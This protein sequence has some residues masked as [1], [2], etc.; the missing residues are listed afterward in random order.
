MNIKS[1]ALALAF[2]CVVLVAQG[3]PPATRIDVTQLGPQKGQ[4]VP[5]FRL[6]DAAAGKVWTRDSVMGANGALIVFSR[7]YTAS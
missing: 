6:Q 7:S 4:V 1:L 2:V 3:Q 5:D